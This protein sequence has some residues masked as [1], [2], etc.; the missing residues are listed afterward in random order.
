MHICA[1]IRNRIKWRFCINVHVFRSQF[2]FSKL[3]L[4]KRIAFWSRGSIFIGKVFED[5]RVLRCFIC[6][7]KFTNAGL[8]CIS[9]LLVS[10]L[11]YSQPIVDTLNFI[12][13]YWANLRMVDI[14]L[15]QLTFSTQYLEC[16]KN[17][18]MVI[19]S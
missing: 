7:K 15:S 10:H 3:F 19:S 8:W 13:I 18:T 12:T 1:E 2:F 14:D 4:E 17:S 6:I 16:D 11:N 5:G 9:L